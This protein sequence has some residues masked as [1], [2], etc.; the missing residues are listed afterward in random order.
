MSVGNLTPGKN[1]CEWK[2]FPMLGRQLAAL[3][4]SGMLLF[5]GVVTA[6]NAEEVTPIDFA[7][8][9]AVAEILSENGVASCSATALQT[10]DGLLLAEEAGLLEQDDTLSLS[11]LDAQ[12]LALETAA[13]EKQNFLSEYDGVLVDCSTYISLRAEPDTDSQRLRIIFDGKAAKLLDV[14]D[15]EWYQVAYGTDVGYVLSA[16]CEPV[17]YADYE[18][19]AATNTLLEDILAEAYSY[20]GT[21]Y[22]YGGT[23]HSGIDCSGF[24]MKVFGAFGIGIPHGATSQ[25]RMCRGVTSAERAPGDLVFFATGGS[26][27]GHVGIYLGGGQFIHASTSSGVIISSLYESYYAR[28]Y[29]FAARLLEL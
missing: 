21:P 10:G 15:D 1:Q 22:R 23:S 27:I 24:T 20:L 3:G 26:G 29:L 6:A 13:L 18:G 11:Q 14:V 4:L 8:H 9:K 19:T 25:Y 12:A 17:H 28:T 2:V 7:G 5:S 16:Y